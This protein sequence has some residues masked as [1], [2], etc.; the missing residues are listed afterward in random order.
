M[1]PMLLLLMMN[2]YGKN[3]LPGADG[4][5][6]F[7]SLGTGPSGSPIADM[8]NS[9]FMGTQASQSLGGN[10]V[11]SDLM[12]LLFGDQATG[13]VMSYPSTT[14]ATVS[15]WAGQTLDGSPGNGVGGWISSQA[16]GA[17]DPY[18]AWATPAGMSQGE[19]WA[20]NYTGN[21]GGIYGN[22]WGGAQGNT[23]IGYNGRNNYSSP[24]TQSQPSMPFSAYVGSPSTW[25][26]QNYTQ[27]SPA[28]SPGLYGGQN[29]NYTQAGQRMEPLY[30]PPSQPVP[31]FAG[32]ES[33]LYRQLFGSNN[34]VMAQ[35][36]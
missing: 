29:Q 13:S 12:K 21:P 27:A 18:S 26:N 10:A 31:G 22:P 28:V 19:A 5:G 24:A 16:Q 30:T 2:M 23:Y 17:P 15:P 14:A 8:L 32:R 33:D 20:R 3:G 6:T 9:L 35:R 1:D 34:A 7:G 25:Q 36:I 11:P 4:L